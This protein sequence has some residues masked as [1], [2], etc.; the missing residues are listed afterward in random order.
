M[1]IKYLNVNYLRNVNYN[2]RR[3]Q[4]LIKR[5]YMKMSEN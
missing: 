4:L 2:C 1:K 3:K 5:K